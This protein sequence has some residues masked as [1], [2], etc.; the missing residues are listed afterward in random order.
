M[1]R[2]KQGVHWS[3]IGLLYENQKSDMRFKLKCSVY[4]LV[5]VNFER[6]N[7]VGNLFGPLLW[8]LYLYSTLNPHF[9]LSLFLIFI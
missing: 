3:F 8:R 4:F 6:R 1:G 5:H 7:K 9:L 2:A